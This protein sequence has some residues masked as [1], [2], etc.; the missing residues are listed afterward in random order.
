MENKSLIIIIFIILFTCGDNV[1]SQ[2]KEQGKNLESFKSGASVSLEE[3]YQ[4]YHSRKSSIAKEGTAEKNI[5]PAG[6]AKTKDNKGIKMPDKFWFPGEFEEVQAVLITWPYLHIDKNMQHYVQ[7]VNEE[8]AFRYNSADKVELTKYVSFPDTSSDTRRPIIFAQLIEAIQK[9]NAQVWINISNPQDSLIIKSY[10]RKQ[11]M[12]LKNYRFFVNPG[13]SFWYGDCGPVPFYYGDKDD[14][15]FL[16]FDYQSERPAD[17]QIPVRIATKMNI[18]VYTT[19]LKLEG[20]N[21][22]LDGAGTLFT[23]QQVY[24]SN[25]SSYGMFQAGKKAGGYEKKTPLTAQ[26]TGDLLTFFFGLNRLEVLP[27]LVYSNGSDYIDLYAGMADENSFVF[28]HYPD[29]FKGQAGYNNL[30]KNIDSILSLFSFHNKLYQGDFI[31]PPRKDDG[32]WYA[33][34]SDMESYNRTYSNSIFVNNVI[35][36]PVYSD[37]VSGDREW[38]RQSLEVLKKQFPG[39]EIIPVD[40]RG[41]KNA[42]YKYTGFD[43]L[44]GSIHAIAKPIPAGNPVRILH[45]AIRGNAGGYNG[46]FPIE[47]TV[48]NSSGITSVT[49][50]WR[51]KGTKDWA[52]LRMNP[53]GND[54]YSIIIQRSE[55][56]KND[57]IE[58][59]ISA[60]SKNGKTI[61]KPFTGPKGYYSFYDTP[62]SRKPAISYEEFQPSRDKGFM[63]I[64]ILNALDRQ[65]YIT[66]TNARG[67]EVYGNYFKAFG[68]E[69]VFQLNTRLFNPGTYSVSFKDEQNGITTRTL[70]IK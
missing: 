65:V 50:Y 18:P 17:N 4:R 61:N 29:I 52:S 41:Y 67:K 46:S 11:G 60:T 47:A 30:S 49:C 9:G 51:E 13:N 70:V 21:I 38:D 54:K 2:K 3:Y 23:N 56:I 35:I 44:G 31:L 7:P 12:A 42:A 43:G 5:L 59:Y 53:T 19:S 39:Y 27:S 69:A 1:Y 36:Q 16:N 40:V 28:T 15:A 32:S 14:I 26:Q 33:N 55:V 10:I 6:A 22:L 34:T 58:Y 64:R 20:G 24:S 62:F 63:K 37:A 57:T 48:T 66:I 8:Y 45:G 68:D 25:S